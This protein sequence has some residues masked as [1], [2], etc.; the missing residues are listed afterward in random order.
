[1]IRV[2]RKG[3][4]PCY[5]LTSLV[6]TEETFFEQLRGCTNNNNEEKSR[7]FPF[8]N[9]QILPNVYNKEML[10]FIFPRAAVGVDRVCP[11]WGSAGLPEEEPWIE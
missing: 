7:I 4:I 11:V 6:V 10:V 9:L 8:E 2:H 1:M 3:G 5:L